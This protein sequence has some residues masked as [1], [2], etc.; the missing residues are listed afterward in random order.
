MIKLVDKKKAAAVGGL[1]LGTV[2]VVFYFGQSILDFI[3]STGLYNVP[4]E[5]YGYLSLG[6]MLVFGYMLYTGKTEQMAMIGFS[7]VESSWGTLWSDVTNR[8]WT[9]YVPTFLV[10]L[11]AVVAYEAMKK[12]AKEAGRQITQRTSV[13]YG[14]MMVLLLCAALVMVL[15]SQGYTSSLFS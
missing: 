1:S 8:I 4:L 6:L 12:T 13:K 7:L 5:W 15:V 10:I 3:Y 2:L 14:W 11:I 9:E